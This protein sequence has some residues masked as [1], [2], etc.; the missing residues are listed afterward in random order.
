MT[1]TNAELAAQAASEPAA[2]SAPTTPTPVDPLL[3]EFTYPSMF[4]P[5]EVFCLE[6]DDGTPVL[7]LYVGGGFQSA[8]YLG[9]RRFEPVFAYCRGFDALFQAD[10]PHDRVLLLG[11]GGFSYPK[12]LLTTRDHT[13]IDVVEI[14]PAVIQI[15]RDHFFLDEIESIHGPIGTNRL[16]SFAQDGLAFLE[17]APD[18]AYSAVI[19]DSFDGTAPTSHLLSDH[20]L[21]QAK[22]CLIAD[23]VYLLNLVVDEDPDDPEALAQSQQALTQ[24]RDALTGAFA[25]VFEQLCV[26]DEIGG[27]DNHLFV[28]TDASHVFTGFEQLN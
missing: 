12:H 6:T 28:A 27:A 20:A 23:G 9:D 19:N 14:D 16:R 2:T 4:G 3:Q 18:A 17:S 26:D 25:H 13:A 7:V 22:R 1:S 5:A 8:S 10:L 24:V 11:G 15:A 21:A